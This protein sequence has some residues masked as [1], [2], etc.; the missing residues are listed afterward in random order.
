[1]MQRIVLRCLD[2]YFVVQCF[3]LN[4]KKLTKDIIHHTLR[5]QKRTYNVH[6]YNIIFRLRVCDLLM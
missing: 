4:K 6:K 3:K 1:M 2:I 5:S